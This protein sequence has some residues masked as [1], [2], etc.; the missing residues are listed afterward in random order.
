MESSDKKDEPSAQK[1]NTFGASS[2][3]ELKEK[4]PLSYS[5]A[6]RKKYEAYLASKNPNYSR[7]IIPN[8]PANAASNTPKPASFTDV[9]KKEVKESEKVIDREVKKL[10]KFTVKET[11]HF[12]HPRKAKRVERGIIIAV[13][14]VV[15]LIIA[16]F[17][18][19]SFFPQYLPWDTNDYKIS[20]TDVNLFNSLKSFYIENPAVLGDEIT[21]SNIQVKPIISTKK[22]NLIFVPKTT[23]AKGTNATLQLNLILSSTNSSDIYI[24]NKLMFVNLDNYNLLSE[25]NRDYIY[26]KKDIMQY[27]SSNLTNSASSEEFVYQNIPGASVWS[28]RTLD[29]INI[30]LTDYK[31]EVTLINGTFR[32]NLKLAVYANENL[33]MFFTKQ[34]LNGYVGQDEYTIDV[35]D[36]QGN[37]IYTGLLEDDGDKI[38]SNKLGKAQTYMINLSAMPEGVYY[39]T[40]T[41]DAF[42][43]AADST[44]K[45][46]R[47][48]SNKA[49]IVGNFLPISPF[50]FYTQAGLPK[51]ISFYY[52]HGGKDQLANINN[53]T[54]I[55]LS[56]DWMGKRYDYSLIKGSYNIKLPKGDLWIYNDFASVNR[57]NWFDIPTSTDQDT[58]V[59]DPKVLIINKDTFDRSSGKLILNQDVTLSGKSNTF[60]VLVLNQNSTYLDNIRLIMR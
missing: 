12:V 48:N 53:R 56:K 17:I 57:A 38:A 54:N 40:F 26:A 25:N 13:Y 18:M 30:A 45:D 4:R 20:A 49:V 60:S 32:D 5:E 29:P 41:K 1:S 51:N 10:E 55:N 16:Y 31:Q 6:Y 3:D 27:V 15:L 35:T 39:V 14:I 33:T 34:D 8:P 9:V 11:D 46:I 44:I 52:W 36:F 59:T 43:D 21:V 22:F 23:V 2:S 28:T 7:P 42:N 19:A 47:I 50:S 58:Q 37:L 24:N